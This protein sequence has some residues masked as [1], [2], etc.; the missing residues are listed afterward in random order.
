MS[1]PGRAALAAVLALCACRTP[2]SVKPSPE[3]RTVTQASSLVRLSV[4]ASGDGTDALTVRCRAENAGPAAVHVFD[5]PRMPYLLTEGDTLVVLHGVNPPD[6][7]ID[8]N[9]IEIPATRP[10]AAG[11]S[12]E[13]EVR[14]VPLV[15][16]DHFEA[17]RRPAVRHGPA[18]IACR[19]GWGTTPIPAATRHEWSIGRLLEWQHLATAEPMTVTFP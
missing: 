14:L 15:L 1:R 10:L 17:A 9:V 8:Y 3:N 19:I 6:P 18:R 11:E 16:R 4:A 12:L 13:F 7:D 5:S 2:A